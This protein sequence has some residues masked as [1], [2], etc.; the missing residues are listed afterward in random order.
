[1]DEMFE[2]GKIY[3]FYFHSILKFSIRTADKFF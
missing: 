1:M 3:I 2:I